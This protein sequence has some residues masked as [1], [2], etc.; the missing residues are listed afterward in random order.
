M[1][2]NCQDALAINQHF[3]GADLFITITANP[4]WPEVIQEL[5]PG[6]TASDF[7]DLVVHVF[8]AKVAQL[9]DD[10]E[11]CGV[12]RHTV[13]RV[14]TI[15]FQKCDLPHMYLI[16]FLDLAH[17]LRTPEEIDSLISAEFPNKDEQPE[18]YELVKKFM[19]HNPCGTQNP[20]S[21]CM[22]GN[23]CSK[24]FIVFLEEHYRFHSVCTNASV[25][26]HMW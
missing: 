21:P 23:K 4:N 2:Q 1:I 16:V 15:E 9:L 14:W 12:M 6:Q 26:M 20:Q 17:K 7:P 22:D 18:L 13:A 5:L 10:L 25:L 24:Y 3:H 11:K 19:V 8:H